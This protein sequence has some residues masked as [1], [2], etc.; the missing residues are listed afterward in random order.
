MKITGSSKIEL[1]K[2][3]CSTVPDE[4]NLYSL[5]RLDTYESIK[6]DK[7]LIEFANKLDEGKS[8]EDAARSINF[9]VH[10][11]LMMLQILQDSR[12]IK[13]V[14]GQVIE[15]PKNSNLK[16]T[17]KSRIELF[18][19]RSSS[20]PDE[21]GLYGLVRWDTD[22]TLRVDKNVVSLVRSLDDGDTIED[23]AEKIGFSLEVVL[24]LLKM[25]EEAHFIK[26]INGVMSQD[27][28]VKIYPWLSGINR[29]WFRLIIYK[30][31]VLIFI[32]VSLAGLFVGFLT[33]GIPTYK[34][35]F[36]SS[37]LFINV[38]SIFI[39]G[40]LL[41]FI[42][43][44]AHFC[45]TR[46]VGGEAVMRISYRYIYIVAETQSYHL[47]VVS[48]KL[49]YLVYLSGSIM[50]LIIAGFL[51]WFLVIANILH[52]PVGQVHDFTV[53]IILIQ[54]VGLIWQFNVFLETDMYNFLSEY[55]GIENLRND[56]LKYI[57]L[58]T[59]KWKR[60]FLSPIKG[61][62]RFFRTDYLEL[63]DDLR[64]LNQSEK[65]KL[66]IYIFVLII[67]MVFTSLEFVF[68]TIPRD[69]TFLTEA[70]QDFLITFRR[71]DFVSLLKPLIIILIIL[72]DYILLL[73][74]RNK[75]LN[76]KHYKIRR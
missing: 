35:F 72:L 67:G 4:H 48:K 29:K 54:L 58:H 64:L 21:H 62:L 17:G 7:N 31:L 14:S 27:V 73:F 13:S 22:D 20:Q 71:I 75:E 42:H 1:Y 61:V 10:A 15:Y 6:V 11:V 28:G 53:A 68:Y 8:V 43:E 46:A 16:L 36:W 59:T 70:V 3:R 37:D 32:I 19:I 25:F 18:K 65:K 30:P 5:V 57:S 40:N 26:S 24:M 2:Y 12:F 44:L 52:I 69:L 60:F 38:C 56:A 45:V 49:R 74:L 9:S 63:S 23:A 50:D 55:L 34:S 76:R 66:F 33:Y 41:L 47:G 51:Y 39:I